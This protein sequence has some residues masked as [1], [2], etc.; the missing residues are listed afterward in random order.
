MY[1]QCY[2]RQAD[3]DDDDDDDDA[4]TASTIARSLTF[5]RA[6]SLPSTY[7]RTFVSINHPRK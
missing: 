3:D 2:Y 5:S 4:T 7:G 6:T 1:S